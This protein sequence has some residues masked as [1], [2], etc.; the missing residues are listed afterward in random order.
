M[1]ANRGELWGYQSL[2]CCGGR[3]VHHH[4]TCHYRTSQTHPTARPCLLTRPVTDGWRLRPVAILQVRR[5]AADRRDG[6]QAKTGHLSFVHG[7]KAECVDPGPN[8][9]R[10]CGIGLFE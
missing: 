6:G 5:S 1:G 9:V 3:L 10:E 8:V 4:C 7:E 2:E